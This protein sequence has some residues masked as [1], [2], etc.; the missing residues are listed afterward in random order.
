MYANNCWNFQN[1]PCSQ[2]GF[3]TRQFM[4]FPS[5]AV[6][7]C[8]LNRI[9][10]QFIQLKKT[11]NS[12][13]YRRNIVITF[14]KVDV[15]KFFHSKYNNNIADFSHYWQLFTRCS[16][17]RAK[18]F[19]QVLEPLRFYTVSHSNRFTSYWFP[20]TFSSLVASPFSAPLL[21]QLFGELVFQPPRLKGHNSAYRLHW[22]LQKP[23]LQLLLLLKATL[24][25]PSLAASCWFWRCK[26][27]VLFT[28]QEGLNN[29]LRSSGFKW[30]KTWIFTWMGRRPLGK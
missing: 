22:Y 26:V 24:S 19:L 28:W 12:V 20:T 14:P 27:S 21:S 23:R 4:L 2:A 11:P 30:F 7:S 9:F 15:K 8:I 3:A 18:I 13:Q 1:Q 29:H 10:K 17:L 6:R 25:P 16:V 5:A